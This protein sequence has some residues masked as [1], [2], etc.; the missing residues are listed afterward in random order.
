MGQSETEK[1]KNLPFFYIIGRPRSGTTLLQLFFDAH[2]NVQ[3][4]S[5]CMYIGQLGAHY[6]F[7]YIWTKVE[8]DNF[9]HDLSRTW[10]FSPDKFNIRKI[11]EELTENA[12][13]LT[14]A[15]AFKIVAKN[16]KSVYEKKEILLLGDKNPFYSQVFGGIFQAIPNAKFILLIRDPRDNHISLFNSRFTA[17]SITYDTLYW[18]KTIRTVERFQ[19]FFPK[20]FYIIKYEDLVAD[21]EKYLTEMCSFL[22]IPFVPEMLQYRERKTADFTKVIFTTDEYFNANHTSILEPVN[23]SKI[24]GWKTRLSKSSIRKAERIAGEYLDKYGY[25]R[26]KK[27]PGLWT[28]FST[29]PGRLFYLFIEKGVSKLGTKLPKKLQL[30]VVR[31]IHIP[32]KILWRVFTK[33]GQKL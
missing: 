26:Y 28:F 16:F 10:L 33:K 25:E 13:D 21:P 7:T 18:R 9:I 12:Q 6:R 14:A 19:K 11:A 17:P 29:I 8:I 15:I 30:V 22:G 5:E 27:S 24:G 3:I 4:P 31:N 32:F 1:L 2:P 23:T 20:R